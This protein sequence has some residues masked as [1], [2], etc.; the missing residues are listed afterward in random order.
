MPRR[1]LGPPAAVGVSRSVDKL[2]SSPRIPFTRDHSPFA[3]TPFIFS[4]FGSFADPFAHLVRWLGRGA[5]PAPVRLYGARPFCRGQ[6]SGLPPSDRAAG[7]SAADPPAADPDPTAA[8]LLGVITKEVGYTV[9]PEAFK[10]T[11]REVA[12]IEKAL[13]DHYGR[14]VRVLSPDEKQWSFANAFQ[15]DVAFYVVVH[16]KGD[17]YQVRIVDDPV[18]MEDRAALDRA[19]TR[20][21]FKGETVIG[22]HWMR[23]E[24]EEPFGWVVFA[25]REGDY[26]FPFARRTTQQTRAARLFET[27][28]ALPTGA[29][30]VDTPPHFFEGGGTA[31]FRDPRASSPGGAGGLR[32][33]ARPTPSVR[34]TTATPPKPEGYAV[35]TLE[36]FNQALVRLGDAGRFIVVVTKG[37]YQGKTREIVRWRLAAMSVEERQLV[38][39][40]TGEQVVHAGTFRVERA[41]DGAVKVLIVKW[42]RSISQYPRNPG[43]FGAS[44]AMSVMGRV[45][46]SNVTISG[47]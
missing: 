20:L 25:T 34:P 43:M 23:I 32:A 44:P 30:S 18:P 37:S 12:M 39:I 7:P 24:R 27:A 10:A 21:V 35:E 15:G 46:G 4:V 45:L 47:E 16:Q 31:I 13:S 2:A 1:S 5:D 8:E 38:S 14:P 17:R 6:G 19:M 22:Y 29:P 42:S 11:E 33:P 3:T 41:A 9:Q 26:R 36:D 40:S 28:P